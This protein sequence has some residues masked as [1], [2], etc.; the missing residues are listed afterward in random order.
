VGGYNCYPKLD[1]FGSE[2]V[3]VRG[4]EHPFTKKATPYEI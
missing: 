2:F 4:V 3:G 1:T